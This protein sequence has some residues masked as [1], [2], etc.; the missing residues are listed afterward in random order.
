[1]DRAYQA[2]LTTTFE[3]IK[4]YQLKFY[5]HGRWKPEYDHWV[6]MLAGMYAGPGKERV[7]WNQALALDMIFTQPVVYAAAFLWG[8]YNPGAAEA[9][10]DRDENGGRRWRRRLPCRLTLSFSRLSTNG[11]VCTR[12]SP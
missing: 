8:G 12:C 3:S 11:S 2:A 4:D 10:G 5:Y 1:V 7:A 9:H 6:S